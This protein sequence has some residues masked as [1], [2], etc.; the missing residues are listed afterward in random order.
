MFK[1]SWNWLDLYIDQYLQVCIL[2]YDFI[3]LS[4]YVNNERNI[5]KK[6]IVGQALTRSR[7]H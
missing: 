1:C 3:C 4:M 5:K 2:K 6:T 7:A